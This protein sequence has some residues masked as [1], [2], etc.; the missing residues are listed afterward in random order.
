[1]YGGKGQ[2][3]I[4]LNHSNNSFICNLFVPPFLSFSS[5]FNRKGEGNACEPSLNHP[6]LQNQ[7]QKL[8]NI[9]TIRQKNGIY[10]ISVTEKDEDER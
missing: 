3:S 4:C 5:P 9:D 1:M 2:I 6:L 7:D 10:N 8:K